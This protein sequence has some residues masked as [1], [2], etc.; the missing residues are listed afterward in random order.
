MRLFAIISCSPAWN[1]QSMKQ[2]MLDGTIMEIILIHIKLNDRKKKKRKKIHIPMLFMFTLVNNLNIFLGLN[3]HIT[4]GRWAFQFFLTWINEPLFVK[5]N[6]VCSADD[7]KTME[8]FVSWR[9]PFL[10]ANQCDRWLPARIS[11]PDQMKQ[12]HLLKINNYCTW[13][14]RL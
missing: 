1:R 8:V 2:L 12:F 5:V 7:D 14:I 3:T 6:K 10:G 11:Q 13:G 9:F 4:I